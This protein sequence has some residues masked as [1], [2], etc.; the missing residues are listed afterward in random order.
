MESLF[1]VNP[2]RKKR[3]KGKMPAGLKRYWASRRSR[4]GPVKRRR[5]RR[6]RAVMANPRRKRRY[7]RRRA[8]NPVFRSR[9]KSRRRNP[10][11]HRKHRRH[12]ARGRNPFSV[13]GL[14]HAIVPAAIGAGGAIALN[15]AYGYAAPYLPA[16]LQTGFMPAL[17]KIAGAL[18]LGMV[19]KKFLGATDAQYVT[20]GALTVV[21]VG[22]IT[23]YIS[24]AV[25]SLPGLAGLSAL[26]HN[27]S[28]DYQPFRPGMGA[29][30]QKPG[31]GRL[32][33]YSPAAVIQPKGMGRL[34][35]YMPNSAPR[36]GMN[37][38]SGGSGFNGLNDGM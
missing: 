35:A 27:S 14:K 34:G 5:K 11:S 30:M 24:S 18:G 23:P 3:R 19:A 33:F 25:P 12:R 28:Y 31:L 7:S 22:V 20:A 8:R 21:L 32:G 13:G 16:S 9:R 15:I 6:A 26:G 10:V 17:V 4:Q 38:L 1:L 37:D 36:A 29:Y 2:R